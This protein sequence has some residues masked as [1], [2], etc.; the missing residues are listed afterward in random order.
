MTAMRA[1]PARVARRGAGRRGRGRARRE[2]ELAVVP[3]LARVGC[4]PTSRSGLLPE[5]SQARCGAGAAEREHRRDAAHG[6]PSAVWRRVDAWYARA[7]RGVG[8]ATSRAAA[9]A[10]GRVQA[11]RAAAA[12]APRRPRRRPAQRAPEP[13]GRGRARRSSGRAVPSGRTSPAS[14]R[15]PRVGPPVV[16]VHARD[17]R[18]A[19]R[20]SRRRGRSRWPPRASVAGSVAR[21]AA[22]RSGDEAAGLLDPQLARGRWRA[23]CRRPVVRAVGDV[24]VVVQAPQPRRRS[25][26]R[27]GSAR[28]QRT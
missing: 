16:D 17:A 9:D 21:P 22:L 27:A 20:R 3:G 11:A 14:K 7:P 6:A 23:R 24:A 2:S 26:S 8:D 19:P 10:A 13:R 1:Q 28:S 5:P 25:C 15:S 12:R 18:A 4:P